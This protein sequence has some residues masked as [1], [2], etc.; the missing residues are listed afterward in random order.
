MST[1]DDQGNKLIGE[2]VLDVLARSLA[3]K[4]RQPPMG[5]MADGMSILSFVC[6][7][8][9]EKALAA[10]ELEPERTAEATLPPELL[11]LL[12]GRTNASAYLNLFATNGEAVDADGWAG[13]RAAEFEVVGDL[14]DVEEQF[15]EVS[16][17][18][19]FLDGIA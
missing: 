19:D 5:N 12:A 10:V 3:L 18:S 13:H 8:A 1:P 6:V 11:A 17:D 2:I 9:D 14:G 16:G 4:D 7:R 15:F